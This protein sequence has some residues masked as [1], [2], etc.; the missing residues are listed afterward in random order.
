MSLSS[1]V[2][3]GLFITSAQ[4][5]P[6]FHVLTTLPEPSHALASLNLTHLFYDYRDNLAPTNDNGNL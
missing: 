2:L 1:E 6:L 3:R 5:G 4:W